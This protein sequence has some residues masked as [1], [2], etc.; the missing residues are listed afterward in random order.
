MR[1]P[2]ALALAGALAPAAL[3]LVA[4]AGSGPARAQGNAADGRYAAQT[5]LGC[6]GVADYANV[7]PSYKV[8][9]IGGQH[10]QYIVSALEAYRS[11]Q[12]EHA[13]M[14]AQAR[15]LTDQ[16]IKDIAAYFASVG[17]SD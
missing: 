9:K 7:Y 16:Q 10:R 13:T 8:P 4:A 5:C 3:G 6:H 1:Q 11:G 15:S 14:Q 2:R 12:R 17:E